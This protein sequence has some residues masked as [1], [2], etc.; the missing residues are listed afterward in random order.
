MKLQTHSQVL[1]LSLVIGTSVSAGNCIASTSVRPPSVIPSVFEP[2]RLSGPASEDCLSLTPDGNTAV[3]DVSN[4]ANVFIVI[5]HR[6]A[7]V[8]SRPEIALFSGRWKDHDPALSP[9]GRFLVFASNRPIAP[10][11]PAL[12]NWGT[13]W[14]VDRTA[15]G[16]WGVPR[17]LP[18]T[19][20]FSTRTYA[21]SIAADGS[22]YFIAPNSAGIMHIFRSQYR[23]G[24]YEK[25]VEQAVG[26]PRAH[27]KD[28][29]VAPDESFI[30]FDSS[31][32][33]K[34]GAPDRLF[35]AFRKGDH[36]GKVIDLG[37]G[38][39]AHNNPWGSHISAD[40]Q[41]LY[42]TSD[43]T[44]PV[45]YPRSSKQAQVDL[46]RLLAWDNGETNIW[47][48]SL[49]PWITAHRAGEF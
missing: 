45:S 18:P 38:V 39:N 30:V 8:W 19:V 17:L 24:T 28:P 48:L 13:L 44:P 32:P 14:R 36:W 12:S 16:K 2:G 25:A 29:G 9:D 7:G 10:G 40:G 49:A 3:Y 46:T 37:D 20:N 47:A 35:I 23:N 6:V 1:L 15:D 5:S 43:R 22:L 31:D 34:K 11:T 41:T 21:P 33:K 4:G 27:E 26:D 42:Y